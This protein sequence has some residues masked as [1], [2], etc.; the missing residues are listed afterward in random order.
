MSRFRTPA[1]RGKLVV[2]GCL[3]VARGPG[4]GP[5]IFCH[6]HRLGAP[7]LHRV[8]MEPGIG[9]AR[10]CLLPRVRRPLD[11]ADGFPP[12]HGLDRGML[13]DYDRRLL[14][15]PRRQ[16]GLDFLVSGEQVAGGYGLV[17]P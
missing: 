13:R 3:L 6:G 9:C 12:R 17:V 2:T 15:G 10:Q 16:R 4:C 5:R 11:V 7:G 1:I 8:V 14:S